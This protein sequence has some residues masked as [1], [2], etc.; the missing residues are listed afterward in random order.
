RIAI[1]GVPASR[2]RGSMHR[3]FPTT[4]AG[5]DF[6]LSHGE[7]AW[8]VVW[9][10][11]SRCYVAETRDGLQQL[12]RDDTDQGDALELLV[13]DPPMINLVSADRA[14]T[15]HNVAGRASLPCLLVC[16]TDGFFGYVQTPAQFEHMLLDTLVSAQ[17]VRHWS[18]HLAQ[19]V[20]ACTGDDASLALV[21]LGFPDFDALRARFV[22]RAAFVDVEYAE[23]MRDVPSD[24]TVALVAA[25]EKS[26]LRYRSGYEQR[27]DRAQEVTR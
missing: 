21:A 7:V 14:F 13:Q 18:A 1:D 16:A 25:R 23:L 11:D 17:D 10:G 12:S 22:G 4:V 8:N 26:W 20:E 6:R 15:L 24:D 9:A 3:L 19:R 5:L 27:L 2:V